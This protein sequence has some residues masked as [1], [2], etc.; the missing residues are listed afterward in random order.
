MIILLVMLTINR[1]NKQF[2]YGQGQSEGIGRESIESPT[3]GAC[4]LHSDHLIREATVSPFEP[5]TYRHSH[6]KLL[7]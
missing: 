7:V 5:N 1:M 4:V 3:L 6:G 2:V